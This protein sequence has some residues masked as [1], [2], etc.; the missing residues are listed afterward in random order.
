M[1]LKY[2]LPDLFVKLQNF[3]DPSAMFA[4][5]QEW[6]RAV[7]A[8]GQYIQKNRPLLPKS[9]L[10]LLDDFVLHDVTILAAGQAKD[11]VE[12]V[13]QLDTSSPQLLQLVYSLAQNP[14]IDPHALPAEH[15]TEQAEWLYDEF[16]IVPG[17]PRSLFTHDILWSNGTSVS[18]VFSDLDVTLIQPWYS[19]TFIPSASTQGTPRTGS[20]LRG[21]IQ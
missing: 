16:A 5:T 15:C 2:F 10:R 8:Y 19:V 9:A 3:A 17:G 6:D 1:A 7:K 14:T 4:A 20:V 12:I 11:R 18:L 13:L 21:G